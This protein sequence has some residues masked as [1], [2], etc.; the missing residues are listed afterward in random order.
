M[1]VYAWVYVCVY[2]ILYHAMHKTLYVFNV[3]CESLHYRQTAAENEESCFSEM[4]NLLP[5]LEGI[6]HAA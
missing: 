3:E 4:E 5:I 6:C 2:V 1:Y